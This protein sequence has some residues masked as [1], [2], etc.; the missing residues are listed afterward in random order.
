RSEYRGRVILRTCLDNFE[1]TGPEGKHRRFVNPKIP[2][3]I[4]KAYIY[5]SLLALTIFT[6]SAKSSIRL[7][8]ILISFENENILLDFIKR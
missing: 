1:V 6:Q 8:N 3:P 4:T 5:S 7:E 2:L